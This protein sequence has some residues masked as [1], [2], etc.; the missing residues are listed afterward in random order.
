[1]DNAGFQEEYAH[2]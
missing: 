1:M 2:L